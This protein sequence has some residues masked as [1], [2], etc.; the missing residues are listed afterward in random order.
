[1]VTR[2]GFRFSRI[3]SES[4][5]RC[6]PRQGAAD[7][8]CALG[9]F[10]HMLA[11]TGP[12]HNCL[13]RP[14]GS[15]PGFET[16]PCAVVA[17]KSSGIGGMVAGGSNLRVDS[18]HQDRAVVR[19]PGSGTVAVTLQLTTRAGKKNQGLSDSRSADARLQLELLRKLEKAIAQ[20][21]GEEWKEPQGWQ[22]LVPG[23]VTTS[24]SPPRDKD[25]G[26]SNGADFPQG[27]GHVVDTVRPPVS[28]K[29]S[30]AVIHS[31]SK[32][33]SKDKHNQHGVSCGTDPCGGGQHP[34][35]N[36]TKSSSMYFRDRPKII[37]ELKAVSAVWE[38]DAEASEKLSPVKDFYQPRWSEAKARVSAPTLQM[39]MLRRT[40]GRMVCS[41]TKKKYPGEIKNP[42]AKKGTTLCG[43]KWKE[44]GLDGFEDPFGPEA[45]K[46]A[47]WSRTVF[48]R[49]GSS[50]L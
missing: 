44:Q 21:K 6:F 17:T 31:P 25:R 27:K 30:C 32:D 13:P 12:S 40:F 35:C 49:T 48:L 34:C 43:Q 24:D 36:L 42:M 45:V 28:R 14:D 22:E 23:C 47:W 50:L 38:R 7:N 46:E 15:N 18:M 10:E 19:P 16:G 29:Q 2:Q 1:M 37:F 5:L 9:G 39:N 4:L 26:G 41:C 11:Y 8:P 20:I 3:L 33:T